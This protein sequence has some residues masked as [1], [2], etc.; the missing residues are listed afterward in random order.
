V[1]L[2]EVPPQIQGKEC[3]GKRQEPMEFFR[4]ST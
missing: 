4:F 1:A 3:T 2:V